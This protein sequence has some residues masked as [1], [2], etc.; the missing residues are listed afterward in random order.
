L[1]SIVIEGTIKK[2]LAYFL[3]KGAKEKSTQSENVAIALYNPV[4]GV[5]GTRRGILSYGTFETQYYK[6]VPRSPKTNIPLC[7]SNENRH[8]QSRIKNHLYLFTE[9]NRKIFLKTRDF[10]I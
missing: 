4:I 8:S 3:A 2:H 9:N 10:N 1:V 6:D 7:T 5:K